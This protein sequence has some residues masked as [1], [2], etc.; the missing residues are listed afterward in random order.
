MN[1]E[2]YVHLHTLLA[3]LRYELEMELLEV[4]DN[5]INKLKK[6][7]EA[8]NTVMEIFVFDSEVE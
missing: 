1:K 8:I 6:Q 5:Y 7:I 3:K 4:N 2:D